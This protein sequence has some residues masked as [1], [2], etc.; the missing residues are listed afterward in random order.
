ME[1]YGLALAVGIPASIFATRMFV[2]WWRGYRRRKKLKK[3]C[4][5][6]L[7]KDLD[8]FASGE[9]LDS[10]GEPFLPA[11]WNVR[12]YREMRRVGVTDD[13]GQFA[14]VDFDRLINLM[15]Q[16]NRFNVSFLE[17][18]AAGESV[19]A[20]A[21]QRAIYQKSIKGQLRKMAGF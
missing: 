13:L 15:E 10:Y 17:K 19:D 1:D 21:M 5:A 18:L 16:D 6:E 14:Y 8:S 2:E 3:A 12:T 9:V 7:Q 20:L 4:D 11:T